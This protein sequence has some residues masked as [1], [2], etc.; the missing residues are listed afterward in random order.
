MYEVQVHAEADLADAK[1]ELSKAKQDAADA[2]ALAKAELS[3]AKA[4]AEADLAIAKQAINAPAEVHAAMEEILN[5]VRSDETL[6][7]THPYQIINRVR[8][9]LR[10]IL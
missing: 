9:E 2:L 3:K 5:Q 8:Q 10:K 1:A 6:L 4:E 7:T